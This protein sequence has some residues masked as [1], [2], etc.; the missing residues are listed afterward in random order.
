MK[1]AIKSL[2]LIMVL[3]V[4]VFALTGC[5]KAKKENNTVEISYNLGKGK[6]TLSVPKDEFTT[7]MARDKIAFDASSMAYEKELKKMDIL[8]FIDFCHRNKRYIVK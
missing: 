6:V 3:F 5:D 8:E 4:G 1:K 7:Y 2:V